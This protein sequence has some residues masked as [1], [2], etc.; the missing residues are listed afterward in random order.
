M[1][2]DSRYSSQF[3]LSIDHSIYDLYDISDLKFVSEFHL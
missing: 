1:Q 3:A 2:H